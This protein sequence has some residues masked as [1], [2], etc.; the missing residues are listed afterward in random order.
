MPRDSAGRSAEGSRDCA[1]KRRALLKIPYMWFIR[2]PNLVVRPDLLDIISHRKIL[3][4]FGCSEQVLQWL[5]RA[6]YSHED[7]AMFYSFVS[8]E[9]ET[10]LP[11][12]SEYPRSKFVTVDQLNAMCESKEYQK[13]SF[14]GFDNECY[15]KAHRIISRI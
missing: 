5:Y 9:N 14:K 2:I 6:F 4:Q 1:M 11:L 7:K 3:F 10:Q 13:D 8:E 12:V 15:S